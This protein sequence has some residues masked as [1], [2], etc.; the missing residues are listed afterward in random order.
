MRTRNII[1]IGMPGAGKSTI[2]VVLAKSMGMSFVDSDLVIQETEGKM[3]HELISEHGLDG[4]LK[5]EDRVNAS[6][7]VRKSVIA[8]GGS[9]VYCPNAMKHLNEIGTIIYL[10]LTYESIE[11]RLGDLTQRGVA[12][13]ENQSLRDLYDERIPLYEQYA[14]MTVD[15]EGRNIREIVTE[16]NKRLN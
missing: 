12:L 5:I 9:V 15:C 11:E 2:G 8:T 10:K 6:I 14:N 13:K 4:F 7:D 16:I 3:L 1:L